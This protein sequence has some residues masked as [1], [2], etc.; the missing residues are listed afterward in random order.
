MV[1]MR[2][3]VAHFGVTGCP[4]PSAIAALSIFVLTADGQPVSVLCGGLAL[5]RGSNWVPVEGATPVSPAET[6]SRVRVP[7]TAI[8]HPG[9]TCM[10]YPLLKL[11]HILGAILVG[12]GLIGVWLSDL[13]SRQLRDLRAFAEAV[14]A[15][16]V[17]YDGVV[18]P[19][20]VLLLISGSWLIVTGYGGWDFVKIPWLAGMVAL[21][22]FELVEGNAVTRLYFMRLRKLTRGSPA[23]RGL[24]AGA[25]T[26][27]R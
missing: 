26:G 21:F 17:F 22:L 3:C 12:A 27:S 23:G 14:R 11:A 18:V 20:A 13:R 5:F 19:G 4:Y 1:G 25:A 9:R 7:A 16:A 10:T 15:I 8:R 6:R 24:H 2:G